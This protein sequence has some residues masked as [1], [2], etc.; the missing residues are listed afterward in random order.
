MP[1]FNL[2]FII[3]LSWC[4]LIFWIISSYLPLNLQK[5]SWP[6]VEAARLKK[7]ILHHSNLISHFGFYQELSIITKGRFKE[8]WM[9]HLY[10]R[11]GDWAVP[12]YRFIYLPPL[13]RHLPEERSVLLP[14]YALILFTLFVDVVT[15]YV[16][17]GDLNRSDSSMVLQQN[18]FNNEIAHLIRNNLQVWIP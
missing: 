14:L 5:D 9:F 16:F 3:H 15:I 4:L 18:R 6:P 10:I 17:D 12:R 11:Q 7:K 1:K 13:H 2:V 8:G